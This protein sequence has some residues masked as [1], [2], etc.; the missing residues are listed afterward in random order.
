[1]QKY[2][3]RYTKQAATDLLSIV[4]YIENEIYVPLTAERFY[5]G[6]KKAIEK[7]GH[8]AAAHKISERTSILQYATNAR[9][10]NYKGFAII[11]T[12]DKDIV[13]IRRIIHGSLIV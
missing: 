8:S 4:D 3:I 13:I 9:H 2:V 5:N 10:I 1:M 11:Y 6:L 7:L 12:I